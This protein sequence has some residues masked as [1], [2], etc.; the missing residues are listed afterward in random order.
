MKAGG[1]GVAGENDAAEQKEVDRQN[2]W[3]VHADGGVY[4]GG[5]LSISRPNVSILARTDRHVSGTCGK[6][7]ALTL[8]GFP[9][10][11]R[12]VVS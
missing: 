12:H 9:R 7:E 11:L 2:R 6:L 10:N 4:A 1:F 3:P 8:T 5:R